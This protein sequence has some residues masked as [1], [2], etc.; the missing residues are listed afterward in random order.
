M[1]RTKW[2]I[3]QS[4]LAVLEAEV[5]DRQEYLAGLDRTPFT[6]NG[7]G[8]CSSCGEQLPTEGDFAR[9]FIVLDERFIN[10]GECPNK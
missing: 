3:L 5:R 7:T 4:R 9:H 10:L 6:A 1:A 2:D 8:R